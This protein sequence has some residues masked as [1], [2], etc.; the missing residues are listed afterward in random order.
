MLGAFLLP[1]PGSAQAD[2]PAGAAS[3]RLLRRLIYIPVRA[4]RGSGELRGSPGGDKCT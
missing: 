3:G 4:P 2:K 1:E